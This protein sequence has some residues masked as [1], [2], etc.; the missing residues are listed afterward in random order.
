MRDRQSQQLGNLIW[1]LSLDG[2]AQRVPFRDVGLQQHHDLRFLTDT[3]FPSV[4]RACTTE[5][6]AARNQPFLHE[7]GDEGARIG[8][9]AECGNYDQRL[10]A[11]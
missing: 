9:V 1:M 4:D 2:C 11:H 5:Y 3:P 10:T 6:G 7:R 8:L